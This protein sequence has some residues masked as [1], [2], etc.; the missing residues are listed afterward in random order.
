MT[1]IQNI[2]LLIVLFSFLIALPEADAQRRGKKKRRDKEPQAE[3]ISLKER[4]WYGGGFILGFNSFGG[5]VTAQNAFL[6]GVSPMVGYKVTDK[7]S[8]GPRVELNFQT[9]RYQFGNDVLSNNTLNWGMGGFGR[10]KFFDVLFAHVE[11]GYF[12]YEVVEGVDIDNEFLTRRESENQFLLGLG[13]NSGYPWGTEISIL[14]DILAPED[15]V[16]LPI[17]FRFGITYKF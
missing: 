7:L 1:R 5:G 12:N 13:Y 16:Q 4:L 6:I 9:A 17:V 2:C 11:Y 3:V 15:T 10:H 8:F 14:Y